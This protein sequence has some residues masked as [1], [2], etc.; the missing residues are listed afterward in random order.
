MKWIK[1]LALVAALGCLALPG[2]LAQTNVTSATQPTRDGTTLEPEKLTVTDP[3]TSSPLRPALNERQTKLPQEVLD[4]IE[5]FKREAR[6]YLN[7]QEELKKKLQGVNDKERAEARER[8][9][10]LRNQWLEQAREFRKDLRERQRE[11][12]DKLPDYREV[13]ESA[14]AAATQQAVESRKD[15]RPHRG[16][17]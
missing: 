7:R 13:I 6:L 4:R 17:D 14:R 3:S 10:T 16:E 1:Q 2:A 15:T 5:R 8:L 12:V 11:L 9:Q